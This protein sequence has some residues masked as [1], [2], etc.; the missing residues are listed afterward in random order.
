MKLLAVGFCNLL[1]IWCAR[2]EMHEKTG[3]MPTDEELIQGLKVG[4]QQVINYLYAEIYPAISA[5]LS[6]YGASAEQAEDAFQEVLMSVHLK[7]E[8][9]PLILRNCKLKS[10]LTSCCLKQFRNMARRR[11]FKSGQ[12]PEDLIGLA[13]EYDLEK[14]LHEVEQYRL[15]REHLE[16]L[17]EACRKLLGA[18]LMERLPL[19]QVAKLLG[20]TYDY[21]KKKSSKCQKRLIESIQNDPRFK[22]YK[23]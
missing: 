5:L 14:T 20:Y 10:Y 7:L 23:N 6:K 16:K 9:Q 3:A 19:D 21:A 4:D 13:D 12:M 17:S 1:Y 15:Y 2:I 18:F 11:K 22:D 8:K